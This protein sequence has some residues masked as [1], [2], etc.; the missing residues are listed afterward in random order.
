MLLEKRPSDIEGNIKE[1]AVTYLADCKFPLSAFDSLEKDIL[2]SN[3]K[4]I[5]DKNG[6]Q[7]AGATWVDYPLR[8]SFSKLKKM[9]T[10]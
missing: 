4:L 5:F 7:F 6:Y 1:I 8:Y 9:T 3:V 10:E 2:S